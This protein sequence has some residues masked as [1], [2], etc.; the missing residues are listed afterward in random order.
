MYVLEKAGF[1]FFLIPSKIRVIS[2]TQTNKFQHSPLSSQRALEMN[3]TLPHTNSGS[4]LLACHM[5]SPNGL[6]LA[7]SERRARATIGGAC[8]D[9]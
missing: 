8:Q 1:F 4:L 3:T 2:L 5:L 9:I 7:G 6:C